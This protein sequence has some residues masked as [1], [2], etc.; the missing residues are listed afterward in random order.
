[1]RTDRESIG[2]HLRHAFNG[3]K[4]QILGTREQRGPKKP[5]VVDP[6]EHAP[7]L[8]R[9]DGDR[10]Y[11]GGTEFE[12][13]GNPNPVSKGRAYPLGFVYE[14]YPRFVAPTRG[15][16][17]TAHGGNGAGVALRSKIVDVSTMPSLAAFRSSP[18]LSLPPIFAT[19][20]ERPTSA[21]TW[22]ARI[23]MPC[24]SVR[25][26]GSARCL[27]VTGDPQCWLCPSS[28]SLLPVQVIRRAFC[29]PGLTFY[30]AG[31]L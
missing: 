21:S 18:R 30:H 5:V 27:G 25:C 13:V 3:V 23:V 19:C 15:G 31:G 8:P 9:L 11:A 20:I 10:F 22:L 14:R 26:R 7:L 1:M 6:D 4:F 29:R 28:R 24:R 2:G 17:S 12:R 16:K